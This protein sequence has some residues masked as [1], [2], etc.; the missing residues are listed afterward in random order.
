MYRISTC[1][2]SSILPRGFSEGDSRGS[3][4]EGMLSDR[5]LETAASQRLVASR[6]WGKLLGTKKQDQKSHASLILQGSPR[7][8]FG[9]SF[10]LPWSDPVPLPEI[11]LDI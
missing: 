8:I 1:G 11:Y 4:L 2:R 9:E 10:N 3:I 5:K 7:G 6:Q